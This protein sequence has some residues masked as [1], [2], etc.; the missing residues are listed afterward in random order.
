MLVLLS[1]VPKTV[2]EKVVEFPPKLENEPAAAAAELVIHDEG[3]LAV[4]MLDLFSKR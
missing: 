1:R 2:F 4:M 3:R